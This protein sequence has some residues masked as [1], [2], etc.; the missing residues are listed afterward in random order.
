MLTAV[1]ALAQDASFG[2]DVVQQTELFAITGQEM[3]SARDGVTSLGARIGFVEA[4]IDA[5]ATQNAAEQTSLSFAKAELLEIDPFEAATRLEDVQFNL[6]SLYVITAR[7]AQLS[8][9]NFI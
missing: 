8:L 4:R 7:N 5:V 1:S 9:V 2:L 3:L 6:E